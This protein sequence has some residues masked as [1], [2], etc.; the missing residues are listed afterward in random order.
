ML[1]PPEAAAARRSGHFS[2]TGLNARKHA[3]TVGTASESVDG[4][5]AIQAASFVPSLQVPT[6][7]ELTPRS[8]PISAPQMLR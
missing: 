3:A 7:A 5:L 4:I 2:R 8:S 1:P 6:R